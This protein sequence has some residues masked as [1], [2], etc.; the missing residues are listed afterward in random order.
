MGTLSTIFREFIGL[1]VDDG[2]LAAA[3]VAVVVAAAIL[4]SWLP[5]SPKERSLLLLLAVLAVLVENVCRTVR[6]RRRAPPAI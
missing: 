6:K 3:L 1:F 4:P 2:S 5:L